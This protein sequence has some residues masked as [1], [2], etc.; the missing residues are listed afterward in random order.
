MDVPV[1]LNTGTSLFEV[2]RKNCYAANS[3]LVPTI[4]MFSVAEPEPPG[5]ATF[6]VAPEP[7]PNFLLA[8]AAFF[9][10]AQAVFFR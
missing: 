3:K 9:K 5:A 8:R 6:G 2:R 7:E 1:F 10:A 4:P